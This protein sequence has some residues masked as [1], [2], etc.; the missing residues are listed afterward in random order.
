MVLFIP[1]GSCIRCR[2]GMSVLFM[3]G[4]LQERVS[5]CGVERAMKSF[6]KPVGLLFFE[7]AVTLVIVHFFTP[8][9]FIYLVRKCAK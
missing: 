3:F 6:L 1:F 5:V 9:L 2:V 4:R 8:S 7:Y